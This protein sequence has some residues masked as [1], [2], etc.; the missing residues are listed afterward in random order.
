MKNKQQQQPKPWWNL[1]RR[2]DIDI[3]HHQ[4]NV[5]TFLVLMLYLYFENKQKSVRSNESRNWMRFGIDWRWRW[6]R[7]GLFSG[8]FSSLA[9]SLLL[10]LW[11]GH[12][13]RHRRSFHLSAPQRMD[14]STAPA[15]HIP[16]GR[17]SPNK[18]RSLVTRQVIPTEATAYIA[19]HLTNPKKFWKKQTK[20][21]QVKP[22]RYFLK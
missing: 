11:R 13:W 5:I 8:W 17:G 15:P 3:P 20:N 10:L 16:R 12:R 9:F 21:N 6:W 19:R 14:E 22:P 18:R 7:Q 4:T 1:V 2:V